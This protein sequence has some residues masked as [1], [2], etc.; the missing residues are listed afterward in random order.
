MSEEDFVFAWFLAARAGDSTTAWTE[1]KQRSLL[2]QAKQ[3]YKLTK[4]ECKD[5]TDSR[6]ED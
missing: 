4:Q 1:A 5:E 3:T 2:I 6:T